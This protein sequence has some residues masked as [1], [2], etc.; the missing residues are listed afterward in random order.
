[1]P[2]RKSRYDNMNREELVNVAIKRRIGHWG[3]NKES[4]IR[5]LKRSDK[6]KKR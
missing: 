5:N 4:L 6:A 1:M 3:R 2:K